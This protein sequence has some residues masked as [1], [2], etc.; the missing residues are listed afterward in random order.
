MGERRTW[1]VERL[2][3][4]IGVRTASDKGVRRRPAEIAHPIL[5]IA[6][7]DNYSNFRERPGDPPG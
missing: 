3:G 2:P 6:I 4:R 1:G 5:V 7:I